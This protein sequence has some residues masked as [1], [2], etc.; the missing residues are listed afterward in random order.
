ML[1]QYFWEI[2]PDP[3]TGAL[4]PATGGN[5]RPQVNPA[6]GQQRSN[7][8]AHVAGEFTTGIDFYVIK[9]F[10]FKLD[11]FPNLDLF[12]KKRQLLIELMFLMIQLMVGHSRKVIY[13]DIIIKRINWNF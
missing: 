7:P 6:V 9:Y 4:D 5:L 12:P 3:A 10:D 11:L 2:S 13:I 8:A 1:I